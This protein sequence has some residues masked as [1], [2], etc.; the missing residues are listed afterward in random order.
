M[1]GNPDIRNMKG[2]HSYRNRKQ[3]FGSELISNCIEVC[4][5][6]VDI[7]AS[8]PAP[9]TSLRYEDQ[10]EVCFELAAEKHRSSKLL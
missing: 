9:S 1:H 5:K 3:K 8:K 7:E 6:E 4:Y 2:K 10:L